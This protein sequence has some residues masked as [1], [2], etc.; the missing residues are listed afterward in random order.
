MCSDFVL[1]YQEAL[2]ISLQFWFR[3]LTNNERF[4][5]EVNDDNHKKEN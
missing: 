1:G 5:S 4:S 2:S 3:A